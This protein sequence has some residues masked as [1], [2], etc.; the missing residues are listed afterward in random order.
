MQSPP[1]SRP[2]PRVNVAKLLAALRRAALAA[3]LTALDGWWL[4]VSCAG[5]GAS[6]SYPLRLMVQRHGSGSLAQV[7]NRLNCKRCRRGPAS[8]VLTDDPTAGSVGAIPP[9]W[10]VEL[11]HETLP[12]EEPT[13][14]RLVKQAKAAGE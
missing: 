5:C 14:V 11:L 7:V 9:S 1:A 10:R 3:P 6:T 4:H 2:P 13:V 12:P 8:V